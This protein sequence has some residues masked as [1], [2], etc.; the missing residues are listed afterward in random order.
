MEHATEAAHPDTFG[1]VTRA[2]DTRAKDKKQ[3][4]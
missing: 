2:K 3:K 1:L 4:R